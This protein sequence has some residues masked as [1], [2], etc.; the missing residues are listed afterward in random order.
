M[1]FGRAPTRSCL[2]EHPAETDAG[3][4]PGVETAGMFQRLQSHKFWRKKTAFDLARWCRRACRRFVRRLSEQAD[5]PVY[6]FVDC[7]PYGIANIYRSLKVG[8]NAAHV[9]HLFCVPKALLGV[10][11]EDIKSTS[12]RRIRS[13]RSTS[14]TMM[15]SR[16]TRSL[17][18]THAG[19]SD[20]RFAQDGGACRATGARTMGSN[21]VMEEYLPEKLADPKFL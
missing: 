11:P 7:D 5:I 14:V 4:H 19:K 21:Y 2:V 8:G 9:N 6:A 3:A 13:K 18:R 16:T 1:R 20:Q 15:R 17:R 10:T 12:C